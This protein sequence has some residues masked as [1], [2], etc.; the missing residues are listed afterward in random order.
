MSSVSSSLL[1]PTKSAVALAAGSS[2][3]APASSLHP[4]NLSAPTT[5]TASGASLKRKRSDVEGDVADAESFSE[6]HRHHKA[7]RLGPVVPAEQDAALVP[8]PGAQSGAGQPEPLPKLWIFHNPG[9]YRGFSEYWWIGHTQYC[10]APAPQGH[11]GDKLQACDV[12]NCTSKFI[13]GSV[14]GFC[15]HD[16]RKH[17]RLV[18]VCPNQACGKRLGRAEPLKRHC[19]KR[20]ACRQAILSDLQQALGMEEIPDFEHIKPFLHLPRYARMKL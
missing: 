7:A 12:P 17:K 1:L 3:G 4:T 15:H 16:G 2:S 11:E 5:S 10:F 8:T 19:E 9:N 20:P 13:A 6:E 14:V 18:Y